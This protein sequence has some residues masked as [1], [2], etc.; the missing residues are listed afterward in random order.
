MYLVMTVLDVAV[1][2]K[3]KETSMDATPIVNRLAPLLEELES[4]LNEKQEQ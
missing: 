4:A 2:L 3:Q 1:M